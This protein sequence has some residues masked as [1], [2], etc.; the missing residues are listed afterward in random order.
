MF[1]K[2]SNEPHS[3]AAALFSTSPSSAEVDDIGFGFGFACGAP[4]TI[5]AL[6]ARRVVLRADGFT[7][8]RLGDTVS[9]GEI[10]DLKLAPTDGEGVASSSWRAPGVVVAQSRRARIATNPTVP[11]F[12]ASDGRVVIVEAPSNG[13]IYVAD[14]GTPLAAGQAIDLPQLSDLTFEPAENAAGTIS[15]FR[16]SVAGLSVTVDVLVVVVPDAMFAGAAVQDSAAPNPAM[17]FAIALMLDLG[18]SGAKSTTASPPIDRQVEATPKPVYLLGEAPRRHAAIGAVGS[19]AGQHH[20]GAPS[21]APR[22]AAPDSSR[23][24]TQTDDPAGF[25]KH[26]GSGSAIASATL[27][28][29]VSGSASL[30]VSA[31]L[32]NE[33]AAAALPPPPVLT[34]ETVVNFNEVL[35][36]GTAEA[37]SAITVYDGKNVVGTGVTNARGQ[38]SVTTSPLPAG[39]QILTATATNSAGRVSGMSAPIDPVTTTPNAI[40][41]ENEQTGTPMSVWWVDPG[42]D[43]TNLEGYTTQMGTNVGGTVQFKIDNLTGNANYTISIYRLGY[44]GGDGA[45]LIT[46]IN[47]TGSSVIAQPAPL[48]D[49]TTGLVDAGNWSVTDSWA[50]PSTAVSGVYIANVTQGSQVFQIPFVVSDPNSTSDIIFQTSDQTW[51]AYNPWGGADLYTGNGP[52]YSGSAYAVSYNRPIVTRDS[53]YPG[54]GALYGSPNDMVFSAEFPAIY[55]LE[56]NGYSVSYISGEQLATAANDSL[57]LNHKVYMDVGHDEYW[58]DQQYLNVQAAGHAGVSLMFLS[59]NEIYWQTRFAPSINATADANRTLISYKDTHANTLIDPSGT[60]TSSFMDARFASTGGLAGT[61]SNALT[62]QVFSVDSNR[63]DTITIPYGM[64]QLRI[65][66][67][68]AVAQTQPGQTASLTPGILGYEWDSSPN[69]GFRPAGL[70]DL[71]STTLQVS[72]LL[73][74]YGNTTG[75]GTATNNLVE[76]RDP[77]SGALVFGA[78]TVFWSWGLSDQHDVYSG[79]LEPVDPSVQQATVNLFADMGVQPQTLE[80]SLVLASASTDHTAPVSKITSLSTTSV[81]EGSQMTVTGT[82]T[83][84]GGV[85]G[86]VEVSTD[87]GKTWNPAV[88]QVGAASVSWSYTFTAGAVGNY[89]VESRAVDDSINLETPSDA[90]SYTVLPSSNLTIFSQSA[91][92]AVANTPDNSPVE[93]GVKFVSADSG[94]ITGIRFYKGS[95][96]TGTHIGDL[97]SSSGQLLASATFANETASGWQQVNFTTPVQIQA[98]ETYI[99][100]YW[101]SS[102]YYSTTNF[103]FDNS[104]TTNGALTATGSGL[105]GVYAYGSGP[106][107]PNNVSFANGDNYWVDV[108]FADTSTGPQ[109][110]ADSGFTVTENGSIT[111]AAS[112]LLAND[113]DT[114]GLALSLTGVSGAVNGSVSYNAQTQTVTFT[115]TANYAGPASFLYTIQ[116]TSGATATGAVSLNVAYPVT[117]QSLFGTNATPAQVNSNDGSAVELGVKFTAST[118][119][120]ITGLRFYKGVANVGSHI[121]D[122]WSSTGQLLATA[123][124]TN[125]TSSGWEEVNFSKPVAI[126]AGVT[127]VAAYHTNGYYSDTSNY[128]TT[129]VTNGDLT[130]P[131]AGNG[132]YSYGSNDIFPTSTY[133]ATNYWVDVVFNGSSAGMPPIASNDSG[134]VTA[135]NTA[136]NIAASAL[137]AND[138]DPNGL[139]LSISGVS[140]PANGTVSYNAQTQTVTFTPTT[141][142]TGPASFTYTITDTNGG[143]A[144]A[145]V[146]LTVNAPPVANNDSG[147]STTP[148]TALSI[149]ASA[150]LAN[151]SDPAGLVLSLTGVSN[152]V[153]GTVSYNAQTQTVT[154][155]PTAGYTGPASFTYSIADTDGGTASAN[156]ALTVSNSTAPTESLFSPTSTPSIVTVNDPS[157][158]ELGVKFTAAANGQISGIRFYKGPSNTGTH[159]A[160]LW[161]STGTLLATA[162][163]TGESASGWQQVNFS[164]PV[165][166][167]AGATYVA[168]YHTNTGE[169]SANGG[170]FTSNVVSGDL[171][172]P[173]SG[174]GVYAYGAT[175]TFPTSSYNS[176]NYWVDVVYEKTPQTLA[177]VANNDG[178]FVTTLNTAL[179]INASQLLANDTDPNGLTMS[180]TGVSSPVNGTVSYNS[181]TQT[182]TFTPTSN[183]TGAASFNYSITDANGGTSSADVALT[184]NDPNA[185]SLFSASSTPSIVSVN[186]P[187]AVEL[188]VKFT[189][190]QNGEITGIRFYKGLQNTGTHVADLWSST[191]TLLATA[192]FTNETVNG[193]QEADFATPVNIT[194]GTTYVASYHTNTG[195]YSADPNLLSTAVSNGPL[196]APSSSTSGGNGVYAYG[197]SSL[198]PTNTYNATSYGVDVLF[199]AQLAA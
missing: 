161:S 157:A 146:A 66:N 68:T 41:L 27:S 47:H 186:D 167:T 165:A 177:P 117:A 44:Y 102:G 43:S 23:A 51:Q 125:E 86:G 16:Y 20:L 100:S 53:G 197:G 11:D 185:V 130:A 65:W 129:A 6:P 37:N 137:L 5:E 29:A 139:T 176:T 31:S 9:A 93:V 138:T 111:I 128:F 119:G 90:T 22:I 28:S 48:T 96:N 115:P 113:T 147:F 126:T 174:N 175:D 34:G 92:P 193:W 97:W 15:V 106:I 35:L 112:T 155:T 108:V 57:L 60:A 162:T 52:G 94:K 189:S 141:G 192:T 1:K 198:F 188:G 49:P 150:L 59:G 13:F 190:S 145:N 89:Q 151:D 91:T 88:S 195:D 39:N 42:Q 12:A 84:V 179:T 40:V 24:S 82:A 133:K 136:L 152:P 87:S 14:S 143:T 78:G 85:I 80:A 69:N 132:V 101:T 169:Y 18:L 187:N 134:F 33:P 114:Y 154:F 19:A 131:T 159:V 116:D 166:I 50:V 127:Y 172:A 2:I 118:N 107:F 55:W 64:T 32:T 194:A 168:A 61:P 121:A 25:H 99:A 104:G 38:F 135:E 58:T 199:K 171:T 95:Q 30:I 81:V 72:T 71:S 73:L 122:L 63:F 180:I 109:A 36:T 77:V 67:N 173:A 149:S 56:Q 178:G 142:Y 45:R 124:F 170:Y 182:V 120:F 17:P 160:D 148:N 181:Q 10:A 75:N 76:F 196:T 83:D 3:G 26:V 7:P 46:T 98:G 74:D 140:S 103:F 164:T 4:V 191:G 79:T 184:V 62:G 54:F 156:V 110:N 21:Q 105:N 158:V 123:T 144:S 163:F 8:L 183:F 153:N 70:V